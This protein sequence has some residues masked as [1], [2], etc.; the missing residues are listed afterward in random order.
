MDG[1][2][3]LDA[4]AAQLAGNIAY[5]WWD[6]DD[7]TRACGS[8]ARWNNAEAAGAVGVLIGTES[9]V[10]SAGIAGNATI[11]GAQLTASSTDA[12]LPAIQAG[13]VTA[14]VG[15]SLAASV[16]SDEIGDALNPGS[17]RGAHGSLGIAKPDVAAPGTL[18][19]SA[20]S[21]TGDAAHS[22]SGTS[23]AAPHVAGI[24]A[25]V[26][27]TQPGWT[28]AQV[29][30]AIMNTATHDVWTGAQQSGTSYGPQRVGSGR[31]DARDAV[32]D[33]VLAY[34]SDDP[35]QVS[36]TF[37][38]VDVGAAPVT[39]KKTVTVQNTGTASVTYGT[40]FQAATTTGGATITTSPASVTVPAG[41]QRL[42][43]LTLTADPA[44]LEREIDPTSATS[45]GGVPR[46]YVA[47][48]SGRLVL[49]A[50]GTELRVPVQAAPRLVS[51]LTADPVAFAD[52]G[53][54]TAP[55]TLSGRGVDSGG[56]TS[57]VAP[58]NLGTTSPKL[59]DVPGF[60]TSDSA[61]AS[62]DIRWVGWTSTAPQQPR[63][64]ATPPTAT[65]GSGSPSTGT[66]RRSARPCSPSS[67]G[68]ST[69]TAP[70]TPGRTCRSSATP[71][72]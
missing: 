32:A 50:G 55:F 12:L 45:Q 30:A 42:V 4:Y 65:S 41:Q 60:V 64:A 68:T 59:E 11:P 58:L 17:S 23:M 7:A 47:A 2:T 10:F 24:A 31:V 6:D 51:E 15:P 27:A 35:D 67:T 33:T 40:A 57:L 14:H 52:A 62:G 25:L 37:G 39:V 3:P 22:L 43:T 9:T 20:A 61:I 1:C 28:P 44:S 29:K 5:L 21:G 71:R 72:T 54:T 53:A 16:V 38:V 66:G 56:W 19:F 48:L 63:P 69:P 36:V 8:G 26:R 18:I 49:T 34:S 70:P 46:E 13:G